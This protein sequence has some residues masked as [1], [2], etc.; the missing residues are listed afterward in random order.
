MTA[1]LSKFYRQKTLAFLRAELG[2]ARA[3]SHSKKVTFEF[4]RD[5]FSPIKVSTHKITLPYEVNAADP[6]LW[7]HL[8]M[9]IDVTSAWLREK[10]SPE[11]KVIVEQSEIPSLLYESMEKVRREVNLMGEFEGAANNILPRL[12]LERFEICA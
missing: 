4:A 1:P 8:R 6:Q 5:D 7:P 9:R 11:A 12:R 3:L 2:T 10:Q